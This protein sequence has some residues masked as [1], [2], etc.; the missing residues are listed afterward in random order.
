MRTLIIT[1]LATAQMREV[2][3]YVYTPPQPELYAH[4]HR[5]VRLAE[6][7]LLLLGW[8]ETPTN[9][10][11]ALAIRVNPDGSEAW[12]YQRDGASLDDAFVDAVEAGGRPVAAGAVHRR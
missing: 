11:D 6:D 2:W 5:A 1:A 12:V 9:G 3:R 7:G 10:H 8:V 4:L